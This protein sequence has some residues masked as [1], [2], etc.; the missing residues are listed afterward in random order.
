ML[1]QCTSYQITRSPADLSFFCEYTQPG[2]SGI[3]LTNTREKS[4]HMLNTQLDSLEILH[5]EVTRR[6]SLRFISC[7]VCLHK[8]LPSYGI[9]LCS[10]VSLLDVFLTCVFTDV[11]M[12]ELYSL[13][14]ILHA[15]WKFYFCSYVAH[16][17]YEKSAI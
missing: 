12:L 15:E 7:L 9:C 5:C 4:S 8:W 10:K 16:S 14:A 11:D 1:H 17:L 6:I 2:F 13:T 3:L